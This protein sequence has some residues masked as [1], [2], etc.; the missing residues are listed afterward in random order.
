MDM[1]E[2]LKLQ[3]PDQHHDSFP[4]NEKNEFGG[5]I[6]GNRL[7]S[8]KLNN[9]GRKRRDKHTNTVVED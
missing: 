2:L 1:K 3:H 9:S 7:I 5:A 6:E 4:S 8:P